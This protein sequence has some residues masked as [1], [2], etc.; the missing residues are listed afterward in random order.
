MSESVRR[1]PRLRLEPRLEP[2]R[3]AQFTVPLI[4]VALTVLAGSM[5]F[6]LLGKHFD[7]GVLFL[8]CV[9]KFV[10]EDVLELGL[11]GL[12]NAVVCLQ[13]VVGEKYEVIE[14]CEAVLFE[15]CFIG[16]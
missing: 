5:L 16:F 13:E 14:V 10:Y 3:V 1:W 8:V 15:F 4:A 7:K 11:I 2:S 6:V 12:Q 9:L